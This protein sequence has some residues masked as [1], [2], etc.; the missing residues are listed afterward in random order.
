MSRISRLR[1]LMLTAAT[2]MVLGNAALPM[3]ARADDSVAD[4]HDITI[5]RGVEGHTGGGA[6]PGRSFGSDFAGFG[7]GG[8]NPDITDGR[9]P[10]DHL[11]HYGYADAPLGY[12]DGFSYGD[13]CSLLDRE[14]RHRSDICE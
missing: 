2:A 5:A 3:V 8:T 11:H 10:R 12:Y 13:G 6:F 1:N 14:F 4:G 9:S 7:L